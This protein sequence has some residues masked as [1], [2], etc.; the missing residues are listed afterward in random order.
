MKINAFQRRKERNSF[1]VKTNNKSNR[2]ILNIFRSNKNIYA[3]IVSID[4]AV[5]AVASTKTKE[6]FDSL[7]DKNG[8][9]QA[10][11]IGDYIAKQAKK[12][13]VSQV[14][15]NKGPYLYTGRVKAL[16]NAARNGGLYF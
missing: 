8:L 6:I 9:E 16:A 13:N 14:V 3:Q 7:K 10:A 15:F 4:G 5:L 11:V 2:P 1:R 12:A